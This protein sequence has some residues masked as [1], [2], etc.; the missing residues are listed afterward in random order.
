MLKHGDKTLSGPDDGKR[1][2]HTSICRVL[3]VYRIIVFLIPFIILLPLNGENGMRLWLVES[4]TS[5]TS[6]IV[7][8]APL[9]PV[10]RIGAVYG[11]YQRAGSME[12]AFKYA[13]YRINKDKT[14]FTDT[15]FIYDIEYIRRDD[16]FRS[17]KRI[18]RQ[19]ENSVPII[20]GPSDAILARH[21]ES[22]CSSLQLPY[23]GMFVDDE[24]HRKHS[25]FA[26]SF[27]PTQQ[28]LNRA[29]K[30]LLLELNWSNVAVIYEDT[31]SKH[32]F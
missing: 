7:I 31:D 29:Y 23:I 22:M 32:I 19:F 12:S 3:P 27:Y 25:P 14:L 2:S 6:A 26:F 10:I 8:P 4:A 18:C 9:P 30:D 17:T 1:R 15:Q 5:V 24:I 20:I 28:Q 13:I 16:T 21:I 11:E